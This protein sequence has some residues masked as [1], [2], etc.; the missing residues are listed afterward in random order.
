[1]YGSFPVGLL[2]FMFTMLHL[3]HHTVKCKKHFL[4]L[5]PVVSLWGA[6]LTTVASSNPIWGLHGQICMFSPCLC[7]FSPGNLVSPH[8]PQTFLLTTGISSSIPPNY[9]CRNM[10]W[11]NNKNSSLHLLFINSQRIKPRCHNLSHLRMETCYP[12]SKRGMMRNPAGQCSAIYIHKR[13]IRTVSHVDV[14]LTVLTI[15]CELTSVIGSSALANQST[16]RE[17][18]ACQL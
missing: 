5:F 17:T 7:A 18:E 16:R 13:L 11:K 8:S 6:V 10:Q 15:N 3:L 1:M 14:L 2:D 4:Y 9:I 12:Q